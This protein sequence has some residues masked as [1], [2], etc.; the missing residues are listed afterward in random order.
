MNLKRLKK[1]FDS[2]SSANEVD[3]IIQWVE[4]SNASKDLESEF[5]NAWKSIK[6][7]P[8]DYQKWGGKLSKIHDKI[9]ME[10]LYGSLIPAKRERIPKFKDRAPVS[11]ETPLKRNKWARYVLPGILTFII[12]ASLALGY[13]RE[14]QI[15][16][17]AGIEMTKGTEPGQKL[18]F[19]LED[20]T[21]VILNAGSKLSYPASFDTDNRTVELEGEAF[22]EVSKDADRPFRVITKNVVTTA[23]GTSFNINAFPER[24]NIEIALVTGIVSVESISEGDSLQS[25]ILNP[26]ELAT[27]S[28]DNHTI[29]KSGFDFNKYIA[30]KDGLIYFKDADYLEIKD[31][32]ENWYG[33]RFDA[34]KTPGKK[35]NFSGKFEDESLEN[36]LSALQFGHN[37]EYKIEGKEIKLIFN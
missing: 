2:R 13:F 34:N 4:K 26:G 21:K 16:T 22:F 3:E 31:C 25:V 33:V 29:L 17:I 24:K 8:G 23:L 28:N 9:D 15:P 12:F 10:E 14:M 5:E 19:H 11:R 27:I 32:L 7:N 36:I 1:Y 35:W 30:W 6:V 37:F 20:G 18:S